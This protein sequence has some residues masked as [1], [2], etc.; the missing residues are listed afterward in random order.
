MLSSVRHILLKIS[1]KF[2]LFYNFTLL[3]L[4]YRHKLLKMPVKQFITARNYLFYSFLDIPICKRFIKLTGINIVRK[5]QFSIIS[6]HT[7]HF[8]NSTYSTCIFNQFK[9][10]KCSSFFCCW[11]YLDRGGPANSVDPV[12]NDQ[13]L[14]SLSF[15]QHIL[16]HRRIINSGSSNCRTVTN[17]SVLK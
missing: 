1:W 8:S 14:P 5:M 2:T 16:T 9:S 6:G 10:N 15:C 12:Q 11:V 7:V 3:C 17:G 13:D 4:T